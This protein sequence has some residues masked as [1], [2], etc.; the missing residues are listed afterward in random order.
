[1]DGFG[2]IEKEKN[3]EKKKLIR[4]GSILA[5]T[6]LILMWAVLAARSIAVMG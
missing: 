3:T 4:A 5:W 2:S 1:M 6:L